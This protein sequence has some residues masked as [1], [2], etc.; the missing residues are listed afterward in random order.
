M[1]SP[2]SDQSFGENAASAQLI[3]ELDATVHT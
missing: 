2:V 3:E 1:V